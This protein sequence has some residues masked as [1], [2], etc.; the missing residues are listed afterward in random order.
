MT[1]LKSEKVKVG[2][3]TI[4]VSQASFVMSLQRSIKIADASKETPKFYENL[5]EQVITYVHRLLYPSL[6]SCSQ[7]KLPTE[8]EF[9]KLLEADVEAWISAGQRLNPDWFS[10]N[11]ASKEDLE[12]KESSRS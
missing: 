5:D 3:K 4:T 12:K 2:G 6:I 9:L 11:G 1:E 7:G 8:E 10:S